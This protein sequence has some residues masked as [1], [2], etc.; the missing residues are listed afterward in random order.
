MPDSKIGCQESSIYNGK[1]HNSV[2]L[3][4]RDL[5]SEP[6]E[7]WHV[8]EY[9]N[10]RYILGHHWGDI[11]VCVGL[12]HMCHFRLQCLSTTVSECPNRKEVD[13]DHGEE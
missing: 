9:R 5:S 4:E 3:E 6:R 10:M 1:A 8:I 2:C 13:S 11:G 7:K 12:L